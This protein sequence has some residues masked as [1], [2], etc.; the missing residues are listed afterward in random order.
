MAQPSAKQGMT[1]I[2]E[3]TTA[4][5]AQ[6]LLNLSLKEPGV[7][8]QLHEQVNSGLSQPNKNIIPVLKEYGLFEQGQNFINHSLFKN[9]LAMDAGRVEELCVRAKKMTRHMVDAPKVG[10]P[11]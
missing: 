3:M 5:I 9:A 6:K 10:M 11:A 4:V 7:Y 2:E 1:N 8:S